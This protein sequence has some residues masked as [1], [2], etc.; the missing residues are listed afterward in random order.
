MKAR[1]TWALAAAVL[2]TGIAALAQPA[3]AKAP[4]GT[5]VC[6]AVTTYDLS[7]IRVSQLVTRSGEPVGGPGVQYGPSMSAAVA[8]PL[9]AILKSELPAR[10][11]DVPRLCTPVDK[12]DEQK[13][14]R[15]TCDD[16]IWKTETERYSISG[17]GR[18]FYY[19]RKMAGGMEFHLFWGIPHGFDAPIGA[20]WNSEHYDFLKLGITRGGTVRL[21]LY[22]NMAG[23][24]GSGNSTRRVGNGRWESRYDELGEARVGNRVYRDWSASNTMLVL[25]PDV[26][27]QLLQAPGDFQITAYRVSTG[28]AAQDT[29]PR[30]ILSLL[31]DQFKQGYARLLERQRAPHEKCRREEAQDYPPLI[32]VD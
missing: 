23:S 26:Q 27:E 1:R 10:M 15:F 3:A 17:D 12:A 24:W 5:H 8:E 7:E 6:M 18:R 14:L 13:Y 25:R 32:V 16:E 4:R 21:P 31:D 11:A 29:L 19:I 28:I 2:W 9:I 20:L 22:F 30:N